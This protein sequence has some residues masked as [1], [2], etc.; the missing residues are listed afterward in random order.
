MLQARPRL[1]LVAYALVLGVEAGGNVWINFIGKGRTWDLYPLAQA[2]WVACSVVAVIVVARRPS[3]KRLAGVVIVLMFLDSFV[4]LCAMGHECWWAGPP[5]LVEWKWDALKA[6]GEIYRYLYAYWAV[7]WGMQVPLRCFA[8]AWVLCGGEGG[9]WRR[10]AFIATGL[11]LIWLTAPQDVLYHFVWLGLYD[12]DYPY[13][14]YL[15]PEGTW[16]LWNMLL[17]RVPIGVGAGSLLVWAGMGH[18]RVA[19][20]STPTG[21]Q[22]AAD[23]PAG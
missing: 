1:L 14:D 5:V 6:R 22:L 12:A 9:S 23:R 18:S 10:F 3:T 7:T 11:N 13:F 17:L 4:D 21:V 15:P 19:G 16:N 20:N 2:F 8:I